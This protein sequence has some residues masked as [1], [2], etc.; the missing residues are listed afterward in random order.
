[1]SLNYLRRYQVDSSDSSL[2]AAISSQQFGK[3]GVDYSLAF[4]FHPSLIFLN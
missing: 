3:S 1:M 2:A 4:L